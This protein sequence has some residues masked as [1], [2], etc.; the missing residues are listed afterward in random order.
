MFNTQ[1]KSTQQHKE[2]GQ[3]LKKNKNGSQERDIQGLSDM[4][5]QAK[6]L[7][8]IVCSRKVWEFQQRTGAYKKRK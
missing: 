6:S 4:N 3:N 8:M 5:Y 7:A 1:S 2:T